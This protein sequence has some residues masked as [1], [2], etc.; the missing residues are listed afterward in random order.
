MGQRFKFGMHGCVDLGQKLPIVVVEDGV[1]FLI[2]RKARND[3]YG[4]T[5]A[6]D[7]GVG[8]SLLLE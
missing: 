4:A 5:S 7:V 2:W 6:T 8:I 3:M 1:R